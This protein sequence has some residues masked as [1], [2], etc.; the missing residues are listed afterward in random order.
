MPL[1]GSR[2][3]AA[4]ATQRNAEARA[5]GL[6]AGHPPPAPASQAP[7]FSG[8]HP[9]TPS[10]IPIPIG[11]IPG[12][13]GGGANSQIKA[14]HQEFKKEM[15]AEREAFKEKQ[16]EK[17]KAHREKMKS[18]REKSKQERME[19]KAATVEAAPAPAAK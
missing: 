9:Q 11:V 5:A 13:P 12:S 14:E 10:R 8:G 7:G 3:Q 15:K 16:R 4:E 2:L 19:K 1:T 17:R 18:L 6:S